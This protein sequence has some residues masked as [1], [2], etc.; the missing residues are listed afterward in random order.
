MVA[1]VVMVVVGSAFRL[2]V[3]FR[4]F[5]VLV[6]V[7]LGVVDEIGLLVLIIISGLEEVVVL[8]VEAVEEL[9]RSFLFRFKRAAIVVCL[10]ENVKARLFL[11]FRCLG[12]NET[13]SE[14]NCF[15]FL[16][17]FVVGASVN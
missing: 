12:A 10:V 3:F 17:I 8:I 9:R 11:S 5:R 16:K 13:L 15:L 14:S 1:V 4:G 2:C 6:V 7:C